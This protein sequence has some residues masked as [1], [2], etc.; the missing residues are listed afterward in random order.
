MHAPSHPEGSRLELEGAPA[1][2]SSK[3]L[4]S[5]RI[6]SVALQKCQSARPAV[7]AD[8]ICW[9]GA[10]ERESGLGRFLFFF[11]VVVYSVNGL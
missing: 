11:L 2:R 10:A 6:R 9:Y 1:I 5:H 4:H 7:E 8:G 3:T